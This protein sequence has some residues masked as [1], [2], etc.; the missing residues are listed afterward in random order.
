VPFKGGIA[1]KATNLVKKEEG[2]AEDEEKEQGGIIEFKQTR[3]EFFL[4][5]GFRALIKEESCLDFCFISHPT[6]IAF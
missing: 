1:H 6:I 4:C 5:S 3:L 2:D